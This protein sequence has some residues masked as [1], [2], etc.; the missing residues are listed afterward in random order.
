MSDNKDISINDVVNTLNEYQR[1]M[2]YYLV[3]YALDTGRNY[4]C[5]PGNFDNYKQRKLREI[6]NSISEEQ[7]LAVDYLINEAMKEH[8][9]ARNR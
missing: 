2:L 9:K 1:I 3:G 7:K 6:Y 5:G 4:I 8:Q